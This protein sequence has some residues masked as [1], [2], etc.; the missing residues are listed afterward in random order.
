[1]KKSASKEIVKDLSK[2]EDS[3]LFETKSVLNE[4][5]AGSDNGEVDIEQCDDNDGDDERESMDN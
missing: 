3:V 2:F 4:S 5:K 1:M